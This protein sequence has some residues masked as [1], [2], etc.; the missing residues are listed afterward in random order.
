MR[1]KFIKF[2]KS[3][4]I[5]YIECIIFQIFLIRYLIIVWYAEYFLNFWT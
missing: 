2:R 5:F 4:K 1:N 3:L